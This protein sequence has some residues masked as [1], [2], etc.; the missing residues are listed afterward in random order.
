MTLY[1]DIETIYFFFFTDEK[2]FNKTQRSVETINSIVDNKYIKLQTVDLSFDSYLESWKKISIQL[3]K[4]SPEN[5]IIVNI[6]TMPRNMI[7]TMLHFLDKL[8][9][10]FEVRYYSPIEHGKEITRNPSKPQMILQHGGTMYP[11]K[12][13][14]LIV[15]LSYNF[16]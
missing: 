13:T 15:I 2:F 7:F 3:E 12:K 11:E 5:E 8:K 6:S 16:V 1:P 14:A 10:S 4:I 9:M